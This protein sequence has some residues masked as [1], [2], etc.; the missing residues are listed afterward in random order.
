MRE[1]RCSPR[2]RAENPLL[3][4][5]VPRRVCGGCAGHIQPGATHTEAAPAG[6]YPHPI[7][8]PL[9]PLRAPAP[10]PAPGPA[11]LPPPP[12]L[13]SV[14]SA[15]PTQSPAGGRRPRP[16]AAAPQLFL[17]LPALPPPARPLPGVGSPAV[18]ASVSGPFPAPRPGPGPGPRLPAGG[19]ARSQAGPA[20]GTG[21]R[22][23]GAAAPAPRRQPVRLADRSCARKCRAPPRS[24]REGEYAAA[25]PRGARGGWREGGSAARARLPGPRP[26]AAAAG[27]VVGP[28]RGRSAGPARVGRPQPRDPFL[29]TRFSREACAPLSLGVSERDGS[30]LRK[31]SSP[32]PCARAEEASPPS[33]S[34][35]PGFLAAL[36]PSSPEDRVGW[37]C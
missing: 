9:P 17:L 27:E 22:W 36:P 19:L 26:R 32:H 20:P 4:L 24:T 31:L 16:R 25:G 12:P 7:R 30:L 23:S 15:A 37:L 3:G 1:G 10:S 21:T 2:G 34:S 28:A 18:C 13:P 6:L 8:P 29:W 35:E 33:A 5:I 11:V 14:A